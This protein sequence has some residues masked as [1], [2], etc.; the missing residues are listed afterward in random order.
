MNIENK[1]TALDDDSILY[2][3]RDESFKK[4]DTSHLSAKGKA[5][6]FKDYYMKPLIAIILIGIF[7]SYMIYTIFFKHQETVLSVAF[8]NE[9]YL[10]QTDALNADMRA[11]YELT[12]E[13]QLLDIAYYNLDDYAAQMKFT[14]LTAAQSLDVVVCPKAVFEQYSKFGYFEDLSAVLPKELYEK[15]SDR[16]LESSEE[17]TDLDGNVTATM[18]PAPHGIDIAG[19]ALY[20]DYEGIGDDVILCIVAGS[21]NMDN[22]VKFVDHVINYEAGTREITQTEK[23]N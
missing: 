10:A 1:K 4:K 14:T 9:A 13:D 6:Y 7:A 11:Y 21:K 8:L 5:G 18:P 17:E 3:K 22:A 19:N 2:Q 16:I 15:V 23:G 12:D 20:T